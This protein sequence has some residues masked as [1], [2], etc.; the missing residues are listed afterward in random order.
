MTVKTN[1][2]ARYTPSSDEPGVTHRFDK[3]FIQKLLK[4]AS[5]SYFRERNMP[6]Y[7]VDRM[8]SDP[9]REEH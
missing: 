3:A 2:Y 9:A 6:R 8:P 1:L 4:A 7:K 5:D